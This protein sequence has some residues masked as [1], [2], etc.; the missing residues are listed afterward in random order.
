MWGGEPSQRKRQAR[1][2]G[3]DG[4]QLDQESR[5]MDL[6]RKDQRLRQSSGPKGV[7]KPDQNVLTMKSRNRVRRRAEIHPGGAV[8]AAHPPLPLAPHPTVPASRGC[9][10][11]RRF[12]NNNKT[13]KSQ[14]ASHYHHSPSIVNVSDRIL[15]KKVLFWSNFYTIS[16]LLLKFTNICV[17]VYLYLRIYNASN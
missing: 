5:L 10:V 12:K 17:C 13:D 6:G 7:R 15:S 2:G 14:P 16:E 9:I 11:C 4:R 3:Q 1:S 8:G